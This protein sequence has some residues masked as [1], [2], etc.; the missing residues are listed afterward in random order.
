MPQIP[1][2]T[3]QYTELNKICD[4]L[5]AVLQKWSYQAGTVECHWVNANLLPANTTVSR[6]NH[7]FYEG[8][9]LLRGEVNLITPWGNQFV[10]TGS[11]M[12]FSPGTVHQWQT[13]DMPCMWIVL[14]FDLDHHLATPNNRQ[15][16]VCPQ[17]IWVVA[18]LCDIINESQPGWQTIANSYLGVI[19]A[20]LLNLIEPAVSITE[21][22]ETTTQL[23]TRVDELL[24]AN[25]ADA[26]TIDE[27]AAEVSMSSRHLTRQFKIAAGMTI[28]ERLESMRMEKA[29]HL[30]RQT[31][32]SIEE[33]SQNIGITN[34]AYFAKRFRQR[35][36]TT[37]YEFRKRRD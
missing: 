3:Y 35:F 11:A 7:R 14:S 20:T 2:F 22:T 28:H 27:I 8:F 10:K 25:L 5:S 23:V 17:L 37:P 31:N 9:I 26:M 33:I 16:P 21:Y 1:E 15:W 19:Y 30:L 6:H 13:H 12:I 18:Q 29:G 36:E 34:A 32:L 24:K 4:L